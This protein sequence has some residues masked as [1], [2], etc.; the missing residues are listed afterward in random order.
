MLLVLV[1]WF[2]S[3]AW[4]PR[5][6]SSASRP[7]G[8]GGRGVGK[9]SFRPGVPKPSLGTRVMYRIFLRQQFAQGVSA[10]DYR[11]RPSLRVAKARLRI[12]AQGFVDRSRQVLGA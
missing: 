11:N 12:D 8:G 2:P 7:A 4:E 3:S 1:F 10:F 9:Q 5:L 6:R